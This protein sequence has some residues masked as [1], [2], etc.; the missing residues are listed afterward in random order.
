MSAKKRMLRIF[1]QN[2][3]K[4]YTAWELAKILHI[5]VSEAN[6]LMVEYHNER[7]S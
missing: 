2:P 6:A 3:L 4:L 5:A 7:I 1:E